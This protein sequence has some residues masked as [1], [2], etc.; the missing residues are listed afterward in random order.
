MLEESE[1]SIVFFMTFLSSVAFQL[2][3]GA[4]LDTIENLGAELQAVGKKF[5][6]CKN[7][8]ILGLF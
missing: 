3:G 5:F 4:G 6:F 7:N 2:G 8:L 1:D